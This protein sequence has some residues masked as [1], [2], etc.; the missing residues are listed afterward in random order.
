[1]NKLIVICGGDRLGKGS[2]IKGLCEYYDYKNITIRHCG[3][4]PKGINYLEQAAFQEKAFKEEFNLIHNI[5]STSKKYSYHDN[6]IIYDRFY[7]GEY[8]YATLFRNAN[9]QVIKEKLLFFEQFNFTSVDFKIYL[10]TLTADP[11]FFLSKEDGQS[12]SQNLEQ[13]TK[14]LQL[15]KEAH[16]FSHIT[17]K[18]IIKVDENG[19]FRSKEEI[20][21]EVLELIEPKDV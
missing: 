15:F 17:N 6:V 7:L 14:E 19:K 16:E 5:F 2:L 20:L 3:K 11:D 1:M 13:K 18:K 10:V 9:P 12:F 21:K 8:V 4:P